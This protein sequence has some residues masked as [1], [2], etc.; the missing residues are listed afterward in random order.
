[1]LKNQKENHKK[2]KNMKRSISIQYQPIRNPD[3]VG[4]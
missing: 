2:D 3:M 1:M 4:R